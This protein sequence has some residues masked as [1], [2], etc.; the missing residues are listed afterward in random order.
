MEKLMV[1]PGSKVDLGQ[2]K[3]NDTSAFSGDK[4]AAS[5]RLSQLTLRLQELQERLYAEH[6]HKVLV[7]L[8]GMDSAGKDG[9]IRHVFEGVNPQGVRVASFKV[10]SPVENDHDYLWRVHR[11]V[12]ARGEIVIFNRSHYEDV[13]IV[14]VH[15]LVPQ[16]VWSR[17]FDHIN[18]F[19]RMLVDEGV[20][21]LKF[22]L[23][24][25]RDEQKKRLQERLNDP[26]KRWKFDIADIQ[27]RK[28]WDAYRLAYEDVLSRTSTAEAPWRIIPA[29]HPWCRNVLV[30]ET[31]VES[32]E[33]LK[34]KYP[35]PP[36]GWETAKIE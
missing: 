9:T 19:E 13:L 1:A 15:S 17:R 21:I 29:N 11:Q 20:T 25:D 8:Q 10:P 5:L 36:K 3:P 27:E 26:Q 4:D 12:P 22:F 28:L 30:A 6:S 33:S 7:V 32:L 2:W 23:H 35:D 31:I 14:R 34:M 24:I 16:D 18:N